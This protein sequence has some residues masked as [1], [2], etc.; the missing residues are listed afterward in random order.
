MAVG[1]AKALLDLIIDRAPKLREVG[2]TRVAIE[3]ASFDLAPTEP[4][5][6]IA[7]D[8]GDILDEELNPLD[9]PA[10]FGRRR[11]I[12]FAPAARDGRKAAGS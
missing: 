4:A 10:T 9:D 7:D 8:D 11:G 3:G 5:A 1:D 12:P 2:V 6:A